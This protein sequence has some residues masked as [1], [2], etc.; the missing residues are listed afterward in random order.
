MGYPKQFIDF[1]GTGRT[2]LQQTF[3]RVSRTVPI[4]NILV[5]TNDEFAPIAMSQLPQL[6]KENFLGEPVNR[7]T[8]PSVTWACYHILRECQEA[9]VIVIP[10]D[11]TMF[12]EDAFDRNVADGFEFVSSNDSILAMGIRPTRPEPGYGYIQ[13]GEPCQ[14]SRDNLFHV[15]SFSEKPEREFARVFMDSGEF[16]WNTGIF[17]SNVRH[18]LNHFKRVMPLVFRQIEAEGHLNSLAEETQYV[19]DYFPLFPNLSIDYGVLENADDVNV[20]LCDFGWADMGT[21]HSTYEAERRYDGDNVVLDSEVMLEDCSD[22]I[23]KL[24]KGRLGVFSG[25]EGFIVAEK[26]NVLMICKKG[27]SSAQIRKFV[28]EVQMKYGEDFI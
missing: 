4:E 13:M 1:F 9:N 20:M 25:L 27:D 6:P 21:W 10:S 26:D 17:I 8:A 19:W 2:Q 28:N 7:N 22:N 16:L 3:D 14:C 23:I 15:K 12:N 5:T 11:Q 18:A 24:P